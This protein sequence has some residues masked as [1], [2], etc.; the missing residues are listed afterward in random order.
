MGLA[1]FNRMRRLKAQQAAD[2][3]AQDKSNL[4][5]LTV[6]ELKALAQERGI[7]LKAGIKK[8]EIIE[9]LTAAGE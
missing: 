7:E 4:E 1:A 8:A 6:D 3:G 9:T 5:E 2:K